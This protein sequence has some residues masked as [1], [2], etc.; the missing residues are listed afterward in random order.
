MQYDS[1]RADIPAERAR[2]EHVDRKYH[3]CRDEHVIRPGSQENDYE[4][5]EAANEVSH[6]ADCRGDCEN[7]K[8]IH[9]KLFSV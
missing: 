2:Y 7:Q 3:S 1:I 5:I 6:S 4:R 9:H 8:E